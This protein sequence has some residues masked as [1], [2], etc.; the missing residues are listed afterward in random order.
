M[1]MMPDAQKVLQKLGLASLGASEDDLQKLAAV[2]WYT[3]EVGLCQAF[4]KR[5]ILGGALITSLEETSIAMSDQAKVIPLDIEEIT[6]KYLHS[7]Q[8]SGLQPFYVQ[9]PPLQELFP[10]L[11]AWLDGFLQ[12]KPFVPSYCEKTKSIIVELKQ[13]F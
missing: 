3:F 11:E 2:Y 9:S 4:G 1:L 5:K 6:T 13:K 7:I 12:R 10:Q 8:Y